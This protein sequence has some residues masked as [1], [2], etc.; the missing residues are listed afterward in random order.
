MQETQRKGATVLDAY[1]L[2]QQLADIRQ[3]LQRLGSIVSDIVSTQAVQ[4]KDA[5]VEK[6]EETIRQNP[7]S[8]LAMAVALGFLFGIF[9]RR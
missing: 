9:M 7:I 6:A 3:D 1:E 5:A 4:A 8:A 2:A